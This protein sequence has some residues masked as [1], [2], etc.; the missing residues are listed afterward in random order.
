MQDDISSKEEVASVVFHIGLHKTG[1]T[2]LQKNIFNQG[3]FCQPASYEMIVESLVYPDEIDFDASLVREKFNDA[4]A[5]M[6]DGKV[7]VFSAERLCGNPHSGGYDRFVV[8]QRIKKAFPEA[9]ILITFRNQVDAIVSNYKQYVREGG[10]GSL[11]Y[12]LKEDAPERMPSFTYKYFEYDRILCFYRELFSDK[13]VHAYFYE[14][15]RSNPL[16][17]VE[18]I[19]SDLSVSVPTIDVSRGATNKSFSDLS[20]KFLRPL[21]AFSYYPGMATYPIFFLPG[22]KFIRRVLVVVDKYFPFWEKCFDLRGDV[23]E[24]VGGRF[25]S[26]N[27]RL[28]SL[29]GRDIK[30]LGYD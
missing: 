11:K 13:N 12:Y 30:G 20:I 3:D 2:W 23:R 17:F 19:C 21:N 4:I 15:L 24:K 28:S 7:A 8:A 18:K 14:D 25:Q 26:S 10:V 9:K 5:A 1:T 27:E 16:E 22:R 6:P 29:L